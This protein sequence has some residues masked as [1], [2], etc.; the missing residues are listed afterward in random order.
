MCKQIQTHTLWEGWRKE[1]CR[2]DV[3]GNLCHMFA[4]QGEKGACSSSIWKLPDANNDIRTDCF[5][6][7]VCTCE[8]WHEEGC[9][10]QWNPC[11]N[12]QSYYVHSRFAM[13][14]PKLPSIGGISRVTM[15]I[16]LDTT[17]YDTLQI[18]KDVR[19]YHHARTIPELLCSFDTAVAVQIFEEF[20]TNAKLWC[21]HCDHHEIQIPS[22]IVIL[23][24]NGE[25]S[26]H[27]QWHCTVAF[28]VL[29]SLSSD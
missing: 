1:D 6:W 3:W 4:L 9:V 11:A 2:R 14:I 8:R 20:R 12:F 10:T 21:D 7:S 22:E 15:F 17:R 19:C 23:V 16:P 28:T 24:V 29:H 25:F 26:T 13:F 5:T 18:Y 27:T